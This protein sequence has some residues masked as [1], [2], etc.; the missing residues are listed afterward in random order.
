M[1]IIFATFLLLWAYGENRLD[2]GASTFSTACNVSI[3][4]SALVCATRDKEVSN[5]IRRSSVL[6]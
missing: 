1:Q 5:E 6:Y 2:F 4:V 3:A